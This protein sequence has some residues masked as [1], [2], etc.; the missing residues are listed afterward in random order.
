M[1]TTL[2]PSAGPDLRGFLMAHRG[3]RAE[4]GRLAGAA[5]QV[6]DAKH[7]ALVESQIDLVMHRLVAGVPAA[8][9]GLVRRARDG[10]EPHAGAQLIGPVRR[11]RRR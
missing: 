5:R 1:T 7:E 11:A 3:F 6:R 8:V 4:F 10:A 2:T 9:P